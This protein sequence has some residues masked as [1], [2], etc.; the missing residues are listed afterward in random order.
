M[1]KT[2]S[3]GFLISVKDLHAIPGPGLTGFRSLV[4]NKARV[5][6]KRLIANKPELIIT[7]I[8]LNLLA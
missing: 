6:A 1:F 7:V 4:L 2:M 8:S 5:S 3:P